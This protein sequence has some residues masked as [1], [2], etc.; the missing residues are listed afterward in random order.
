MKRF[1]RLLSV[2]SVCA[3]LCTL[4]GCDRV[5]RTVD[6]LNWEIKAKQIAEEQAG[7]ILDCLKT[8]KTEK[9]EKQFCEN[10]SS[11]HDLKAE[12]AK[13]IEFID[14]NIIDDGRWTGMASGG[15]AVDNGETTMLEPV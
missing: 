5:T 9:L 2:I 10:V 4:S 3:I 15:E 13:A 8:G 1:K 6:A 11:S 12:I 7:I 14:G